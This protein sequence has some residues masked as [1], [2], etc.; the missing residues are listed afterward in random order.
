MT[1]RRA[2]ETLTHSWWECELV[3]PLQKS[4]L[5]PKLNKSMHYDLGIPLLDVDLAETHTYPPK[6][7]YYNIHSS[8]I[9]QFPKPEIT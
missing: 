7:V 9:H 3:Q 6:Q 2:T 4:S 5:P 1:G 8:I